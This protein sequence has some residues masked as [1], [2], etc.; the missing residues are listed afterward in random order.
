MELKA[1]TV[2]CFSWILVQLVII[3][4]ITLVT[5]HALPLNDFSFD[6]FLTIAKFSAGI[7]NFNMAL[8][9]LL[10][11]RALV[12][13]I[14]DRVKWDVM[15]AGGSL[16]R[17]HSFLGQWIM[18]W[19]VVHVLAHYLNYALYTHRNKREFGKMLLES[20]A[21][22]T[23]HAIL[24]ALL[25]ITVTS[26]ARKQIS[27]ELWLLSH[28]CLF[29]ITIF[30]MTIH[31]IYCTF[32]L[33][34]QK[35]PRGTTWMWLF[36]PVSIFLMDFGYRCWR[37]LQYVHLSKIIRHGGRVV[38]IR[39]R[40][41]GGFHY[42]YRPGQYVYVAFKHPLVPWHYRCQW[43]PFTLTST[44]DEIYCD[45]IHVKVVIATKDTD[46]GGGDSGS[47]E[48]R[49]TT[50]TQ[51]LEWVCINHPEMLRLYIDGPFGSPSQAHRQYQHA[52]CIGAGIGQTPFASILKSF[53]AYHHDM[54]FDDE[55]YQRRKSKKGT[56]FPHHVTFIGCCREWESFE[57]FR[58][59]LDVLERGLTRLA[60][61][62][63]SLE[64]YYHVTNTEKPPPPELSR[65]ENYNAVAPRYIMG[66]PNW[67]HLFKSVKTKQQRLDRAEQKVGIFFCGPPRMRHN[68]VRAAEASGLPF[69][70]HYESF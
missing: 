18:G 2:V 59:I 69:D 67:Q 50:W 57:W 11:S 52:I 34:T 5:V 30:L 55:E 66:R 41:P 10:L 44:E 64:I 27:W 39:F 40:K 60:S 45:S 61:T 53:Y 29:L 9:I 23:G 43:H 62:R 3:T 42:R 31:G 14:C 15:P 47:G 58:D 63:N 13:S 21:S 36:G 46:G 20:K 68:V 4:I 49:R 32:K 56:N 17:V 54:Q 35:C 26:L 8:M 22:L 19:S 24:I 65:I 1:T 16:D 33:S 28:K 6:L 37:S 12:T 48:K 25:L 51:E 7:L 38:E 70:F